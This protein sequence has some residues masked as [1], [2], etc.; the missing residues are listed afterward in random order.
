MQRRL[1]DFIFHNVHDLVLG[2]NHAGE[3]SAS[4][5]MCR[6]L[7]KSATGED[8]KKIDRLK[9]ERMPLRSVSPFRCKT[10]STPAA[11]APA[12][13][14]LLPPA[15]VAASAAAAVPVPAMCTRIHCIVMAIWLKNWPD[16]QNSTFKSKTTQQIN[17]HSE[18]FQKS[19]RHAG[20][21]MFR[22]T[23]YISENSISPRIIL[24][25][26]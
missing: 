10:T 15:S 1:R 4:R 14:L 20:Y 8:W 17:W 6:V 21:Q 9:D 25:V 12:A 22:K 19:K 3:W 2:S 23:P 16:Q 18:E 7:R 13:P 5:L 24:C 26:T 11:V